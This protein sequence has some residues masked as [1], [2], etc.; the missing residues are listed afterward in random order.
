MGTG[1]RIIACLEKDSWMW[2]PGYLVQVRIFHCRPNA[3]KWCS[4]G[5]EGCM[6]KFLLVIW[7]SELTYYLK[8]TQSFSYPE[9]PTPLFYLGC[10]FSYSLFPSSS[11][12]ISTFQVSAQKE[13]PFLIPKQEASQHLLLR[14][15]NALLLSHATHILSCLL[16]NA[17]PP[18]HT[19]NSLRAEIVSHLGVLPQNQTDSTA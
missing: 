18:H 19:V 14:V 8:V 3:F 2:V 12:L 11:Q 10:S 9:L 13:A 17:L 1:F 5:H 6:P 7:H 16:I 4:P 15:C